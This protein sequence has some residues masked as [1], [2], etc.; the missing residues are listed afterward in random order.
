MKSPIKTVVIPA[1]LLAATVAFSAQVESY[2]PSASSKTGSVKKGATAP[3]SVQQIADKINLAN[4]PAPRHFSEI[5]KMS[6]AG[7][8]EKAIVSFIQASPGFRL[9]ADDI[10]YLH[11]RGISSTIISTLLAHPPKAQ[12]AQAAAPVPAAPPQAAYA[13]PAQPVYVT[14]P[15]VYTAPSYVYRYPNV[16]ISP[17]HHNRPHFAFS[18]GHSFPSYNHFYRP[19]YHCRW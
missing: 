8:D 10:I 19:Q 7:V 13:A 4:A 2:S 11:D 14:P 18:Y 1:A 3:A 5:I 12:I 6:E 15:A 16:Y 17:H 9:S